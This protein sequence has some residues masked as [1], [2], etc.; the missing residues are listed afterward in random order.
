M[1]R[2]IALAAVLALNGC[3]SAP[4]YIESDFVYTP[5]ERYGVVGIRAA[6]HVAGR[7]FDIY[8]V[9]GDDKRE[10]IIDTEMEWEPG[11]PKPWLVRV[12]GQDQYVTHFRF[13]TDDSFLF[14]VQSLEVASK[15]SSYY[16]AQR[17]RV[18]NDQILSIPKLCT[19]KQQQ[20]NA[21]ARTAQVQ[22]EK[23]DDDLIT[24][25]VARTGAKPMLP[26]RNQMD[27]NNLV[28]LF[29]QTGASQH[30]GKFV[31]AADGDYRVAQVVGSRVLLVSMTNPSYF[32]TITII[33]DKEVLEGQFWSSVSQG[34]LQLIGISTYQTVLGASRQTILFKT[35]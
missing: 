4:E 21:E 1:K 12:S 16:F 5:I 31:W 30:Q 11:R 6:S 20:L 26:G 33:T 15:L 27:F 19:E 22:A 23:K 25:V 29:Q 24:A 8:G 28:L 32:P 9:C 10:Y 17:I 7:N 3:V 13:E 14:A 35:I 2:I 34:P 18:V